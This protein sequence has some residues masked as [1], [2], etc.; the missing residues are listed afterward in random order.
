V[1]LVSWNT[2][3]W[4]TPR[5][6]FSELDHAYGPLELDV[7][8]TPE[9]AKCRR[10]YTK[11]D[12]GLT[13]PWDAPVWLNPPYSKP[14]P[15]LAKAVKTADAGG[16]VV[17]LIKADTSTKW[18]HTYVEPVRLGEKPGAVIFLKG[19]L[20]FGKKGVFGPPATFPSAV[21]IFGVKP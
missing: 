10:Y 14:A 13:K 1:V 7:C 12:D 17:A 8:A 9:T 11:E 2:D 3:D 19:R 4:E 16:Y 20:R 21:V 6:L 18:W 15:W 5:M